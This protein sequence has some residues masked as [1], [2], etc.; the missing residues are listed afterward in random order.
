MEY[1]GNVILRGYKDPSSNLWTL[2]LMSAR[3]QSSLSRPPPIV[4]RTLHP[5]QTL[6][7]GVNLASFTNSVRT[8]GNGV[9]FAHQLL[10]NPT[11]S[12]L[13]K[14]VQK[15]FL[16]GCPNMS[17]KLILK[18]LNPSPATAKG[19]MKRPH[20]GIRST[21]PKTHTGPI[22]VPVPIIPP[23]L[24]TFDVAI[25][26]DKFHPTIP[27][28]ALIDDNTNKSIANIFCFGA[29]ADRQSGIVYNDLT[30]NFPFMSYNGSVCF[31]VV[32]HYESN[33]ILAIPIAGLNDKMIF[34]AYKIAFNELVAKGFK[35]KLNI[36]DNQATKYIKKSH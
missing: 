7:D 34:E 32:Y 35:P 15:G 25:V 13:L 5:N 18:Y 8:Q 33:A 17:E 19:H 16:K 27:G 23:V 22:V 9:K 20:H 14:A 10:C 1:N 6:H 24:P 21:R 3:M 4:D 26:H 30:G 2:P 12:T 36:M 29:F 31:L 28:P 11:I